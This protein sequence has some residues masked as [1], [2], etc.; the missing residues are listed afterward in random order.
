MNK[1]NVKIKYLIGAYKDSPEY[2][3]NED[4]LFIMSN[5][6]FLENGK[7]FM[8]TYRALDDI[9]LVCFPSNIVCEKL[10]IDEKKSQEYLDEM[11]NKNLISVMKKTRFSIYYQIN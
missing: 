4:I 5:W 8:H 10:N 1:D 7:S 3:T 11:E 6:Y 9:G 2:P